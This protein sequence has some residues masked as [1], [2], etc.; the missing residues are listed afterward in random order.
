MLAVI[1]HFWLGVA[2]VIPALLATV[3]LT[4]Q[5]LAKTEAPKYGRDD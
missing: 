4:V 2:I 3:A 1:W 5:Y